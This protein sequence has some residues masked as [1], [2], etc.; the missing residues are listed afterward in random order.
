LGELAGTRSA[1]LP[2]AIRIARVSAAS[3]ALVAVPWAQM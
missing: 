3:L 2:S 1:S